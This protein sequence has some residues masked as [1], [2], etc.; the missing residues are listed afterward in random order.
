M[1][2]T[3]NDWEMQ[4]KTMGP[5]SDGTSLY[6]STWEAEAE[7]GRSL[8]NIVNSRPARAT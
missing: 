5:G 7:A 6:P 3:V 8:V 1:I 2:H 4:N